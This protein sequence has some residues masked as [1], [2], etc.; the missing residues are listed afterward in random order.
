MACRAC[1]RWRLVRI[2]GPRMAPREPLS[3]QGRSS[4]P[5]SHACRGSSVFLG[6]VGMRLRRCIVLVECV[7]N[8]RDCMTL[9]V[10]VG[11][12]GAGDVIE[13]DTV[14]SGGAA[15][16]SFRPVSP[17]SRPAA[18]ARPFWGHRK[19]GKT[20]VQ[21]FGRGGWRKW[22]EGRVYDAAEGF[23]GRCLPWRKQVLGRED[24]G[25]ISGLSQKI[26][27]LLDS[28]QCWC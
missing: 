12:R 26:H 22:G 17:S 8:C 28:L 18:G 5:L 4:C 14:C 16:L 6:T 27:F 13:H 3:G 2:S 10:G 11:L 9:Q 15:P 23:W 19:R 25:L 21:S 24:F 1:V 20:K 7:A